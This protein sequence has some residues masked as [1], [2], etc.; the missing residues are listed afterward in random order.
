MLKETS[1]GLVNEMS[2]EQT[3]NGDSKVLPGVARM[4]ADTAIIPGTSQFIN[5]DVKSGALHAVAGLAARAV[6]GPIGW[7]AIAANSTMKSTT[8][9]GLIGGKKNGAAA[10]AEE[11]PG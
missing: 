3:N 11:A 5:G 9:S 2:D 6:L 1:Q 7:F 4:V 8:G 10:P